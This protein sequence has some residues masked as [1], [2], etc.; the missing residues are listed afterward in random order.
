MAASPRLW[1]VRVRVHRTP[2]CLQTR[3]RHV[4]RRVRLNDH[5][6]ETKVSL[7]H[8]QAICRKSRT[9]SAPSNDHVHGRCLFGD[10]FVPRAVP[11]Q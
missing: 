4:L 9:A 8:V 5:A 11:T 3:N 6:H 2:A 10:E 7:A 1:T